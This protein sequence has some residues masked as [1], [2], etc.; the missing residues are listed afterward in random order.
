VARRV[1]DP[2]EDR[3]L[4]AHTLGRTVS[5]TDP[6][7]HALALMPLAMS[8][9]ILAE[10]A[11][12]LI[13]EATVVGVREVRA[14]R[15]L[16]WGEDPQTLEVQARRLA[17]NDGRERVHVEL[18]EVAEGAEAGVP[19]VEAE[20]A[21]DDRFP[22]PPPPLATDLREGRSSRFG[23]GE[24]YDDI[25]FHGDCWRAVRSVDVVAP[26]AA[27]SRLEVLPPTGLMRDTPKPSFVLDPVMLDAAGQVIGCWTADRL[28]RGKVVFPFR[29]AAL[30]LYRETPAE[31][32]TLDCRA[33]I[34][35]VG[36]A[37][38]RSDIDVLDPAGR[39]WMRLKGWEDKRFDVPD[40]FRPLTVPSRLAPLTAPWQLPPPA[41]APLA[42]AC[43]RLD[44]R[45]PAD[46]SLWTGVWSSRVLGRREREL[47][48]ALRLPQLRKLEW[49]GARTAA[50]EAVAELLRDAHGLDLL[51]ADIEILGGEGGAPVVAAPGVERLGVTPVVSLSHTQGEAVALAALVRCGSG[52][53]IGIDIEHLS[54]R[55]AGFAEVAH[56]E[57]ERRLLEVIGPELADEW[58]LR[59]WCAKEA[60]GKAL[61]SGMAPGR[62]EAPTLVSLDPE[63]Q[64]V[65]VAVA[66][67]R[68]VAHTHREGD[69]VVAT[70]LAPGGGHS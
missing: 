27:H 31:G 30:D 57:D 25:M 53:S 32:E 39:P 68:L 37:L 43:R 26:R 1:F 17:S 35:L 48:A 3:Y 20:V 44:A 40:R 15:W 34:E 11:A 41:N 62:P 69:L 19:A 56:S 9:E 22:A 8:L 14:H 46:G 63:R 49:L 66:G 60:V 54:P 6:E 21:L 28:A 52:E 13:P 70:A 58:L 10:G 55:P 24:L 36:D 61:G 51:P 64:E 4:L 45:L 65:V 67:R 23:P 18:R 29:L 16:A 7:L 59:S 12:A 50:K 42:I 33:A 2:A 47:F 38:V 5:H